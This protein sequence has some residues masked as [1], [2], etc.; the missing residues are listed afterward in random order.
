MCALF[1]FTDFF[2]PIPPHTQT[3]LTELQ[4][5]SRKYL[6]QMIIESQSGLGGTGL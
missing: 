1:S 4:E 6:T 5:I 3:H 2:S